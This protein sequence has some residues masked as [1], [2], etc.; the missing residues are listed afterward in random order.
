MVLGH[1]SQGLSWGSYM[2]RAD[3]ELLGDRKSR[4]GPRG[5]E[6]DHSGVTVLRATA[7]VSG[8]GQKQG[9]Q[10]SMTFSGRAGD[11]QPVLDVCELVPSRRLTL[12][13]D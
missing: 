7:W 10:D 2:L 12:T 4:V 3:T 13:S 6:K 9:L 11:R 1:T 5:Q 8:L